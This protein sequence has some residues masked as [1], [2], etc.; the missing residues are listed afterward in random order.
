MLVG[1]HPDRPL[2]HDPGYVYVDGGEAFAR[3]HTAAYADAGI[4]WISFG[5]SVWALQHLRDHGGSAYLP[6][7][8]IGDDLAAGTLVPLQGAPRFTRPIVAVLN[9]SSTQGW[10]WLDAA[11]NEVKT[12]LT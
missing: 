12:S 6:L 5:S 10:P 11:L 4:A 7:R 2:R 3:G 9:T 1:D 8:L